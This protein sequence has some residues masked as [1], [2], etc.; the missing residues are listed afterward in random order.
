MDP[1]ST[2]HEYQQAPSEENR[3]RLAL[4]ILPIIQEQC[5]WTAGYMGKMPHDP[6]LDDMVQA[7]V[8]RVLDHVHKLVGKTFETEGQFRAYV[9]K[10]ARG[11]SIKTND[12]PLF[13][14]SRRNLNRRVKATE[15]PRPE[16]LPGES[17]EVSGE[18]IAGDNGNERWQL[19]QFVNEVAK[20]CA[21][22]WARIAI[23]QVLTGRSDAATAELVKMSKST[24]QNRRKKAMAELAYLIAAKAPEAIAEIGEK[25]YPDSW[26]DAAA[27]GAEM[28]VLHIEEDE[29]D[30]A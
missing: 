4:A 1:L 7:S 10:V 18:F 15:Q 5:R 20:Q 29:R 24:W 3:N 13:G 28:R 8:M 21:S 23:N 12:D 25:I 9:R 2:F 17:D 11:E 22:D 26:P 27:T 6:L 19:V 14:P 30:A 16:Q